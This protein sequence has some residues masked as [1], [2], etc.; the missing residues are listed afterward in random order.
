VV[1]VFEKCRDA[2]VNISTTRIV[3]VRALGPESLFEDIFDFG[4]PRARNREVHSIGSGVVVHEGG[5]IVTNA[6][7][8]SQASDVRVTFA[9]G[10][11]ESADILAVDADHDLAVL[12][13]QA[14]RPLACLKLGRSGD[15]MVGETVVAIGNPLGL[16][17][18][19]TAGIVS[20]L[21]RTLEFGRDVVYR[22]LIQ[23]DASIN[24]GNSG[25][26]LLNANGELIGINT[27]IRGDAQ[28]IGFA[29]PVDRLWEWLPVMLD[30]EH[31]ERV[32]FGLRVGG[33]DAQVLDVRPESPAAAAEIKPGDRIVRL[34][35]QPIRNGIDYYARLLQHQPGDKIR[36]AV[37]R[38]NAVVN[39]V[40]PLQ[41]IPIPDGH[42]LAR[43][44]LGLDLEPIPDGLRQRYDL[45]PHIG[46]IVV[47]TEPGGPADRARIERG[48]LILRL[49]GGTTA[50]A[51]DV[52]LALERVSSGSRVV[53]DGLRLDA[54]PPFFWTVSVR[55]RQ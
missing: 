53:V 15:I 30:P 43:E 3:R 17:H 12:K 32:R 48:D 6:H 18:T 5:Y 14:K 20:A 28:N 46:L 55:A 7:V 31:R 35:D 36:L 21:D 41:P 45:P 47:D 37:Q 51:Q 33:P 2:V 49:D 16:Q 23:T 9:D 40:V 26:P 8:V 29:I 39:A 22:G 13:I 10:H 24:P 25:G 19:V 52:G 4:Q 27:A 38:G 44:L 50:T 54:D 11:A 1:E 34:N 42:K